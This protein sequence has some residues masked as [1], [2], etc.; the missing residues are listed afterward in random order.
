MDKNITYSGVSQLR[1]LQL[2]QIHSVPRDL[3]VV[4]SCPLLGVSVWETPLY[5]QY[6]TMYIQYRYIQYLLCIGVNIYQRTKFIRYVES[7][8]EEGGWKAECDPETSVVNSKYYDVIMAADGK[9]N[10]LKFNKKEFRAKLAIGITFNFVNRN[11][12]RENE[13]KEIP[14]ISFAFNQDWF[15][16]LSNEHGIDLENITYYKVSAIWFRNSCKLIENFP[17]KAYFF[18]LQIRVK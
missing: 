7:L 1:T 2:W 3:S 16:T 13:V 6:I 15:N 9:K 11:T 5:I 8:T 17:L 14:G 10:T 4:E 12:P 18:K